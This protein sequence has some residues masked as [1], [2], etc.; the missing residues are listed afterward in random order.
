MRYKINAKDDQEY[1][2]NL[3]NTVMKLA[4][5][6][7]DM[8]QYGTRMSLSANEYAVK[9]ATEFLKQCPKNR[10]FEE[11]KGTTATTNSSGSMNQV[12]SE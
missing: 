5:P 11:K 9:K 1:A 12:S 2:D 8:D 7:V 4:L 6:E 10:S 3:I